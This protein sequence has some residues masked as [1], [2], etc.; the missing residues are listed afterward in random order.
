MDY[1]ELAD[2]MHLVTFKMSEAR[3]VDVAKANE[4]AETLESFYARQEL[5][6]DVL[7]NA[8]FF[9]MSNGQPVMTLEDE[10][11]IRSKSDK[12]EE[13]I[14]VLRTGRFVT[15]NF[16][17]LAGLYPGLT[18]FVSGYPVLVRDRE[19]GDLSSSNEIRARNRR[20]ILGLRELKDGDQMI[21][22]L[23]VDDPGISLDEAANL[24]KDTLYMDYA[25]NLDGGGSQR[26]LVK[27]DLKSAKVY[28]RPVD[29]V[30]AVYLVH[31]VG[32]RVQVGAYKLK[33][34]ADRLC[35]KIVSLTGKYASVYEDAKV[36][37]IDG[38]YKVQVGC[39]RYKTSAYS[40]KRD[41]ISQGFNAF[42]TTTNL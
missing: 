20:T 4:P 7:T 39:F 23:S 40:V 13:G 16:T 42:I 28:S 35:T 19:I 29:S 27:G 8:G 17:T 30:L 36:Y 1:R 22:L 9:N 11:T 33:C 2:G 6:P 31:G 14:G 15:G 3:L 12:I 5:K 34:S 10:G 37:K 25:I 18:D 32:Y 26:M 24:M 21:T 38:L 41:L